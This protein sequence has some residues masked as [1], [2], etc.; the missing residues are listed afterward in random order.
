[1]LRRL[2]SKMR[3]DEQG[4]T[5]IELMIV[6]LVILVLAAILLPQFGLAR[7]RARKAS[8]VSNQRNLETAVAMWQTDNPSTSL[9]QG[10]MSGT[11]V[12]L[13]GTLSGTPQYALSGTYKEPDDTGATQTS[14]AD[15]F[16]S[17]GGATAN[18]VAPSYGHVV[19]R[20]AFGTGANPDP[21][22]GI[23]PI[24]EQGSGGNTLNHARGASASP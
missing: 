4:F 7:E 2:M 6:I 21:W 24:T 19:C 10:E 14:G 11:S 15:Y 9:T 20:F 22:G 8:C 5:L 1:M 16:L 12:P 23:G 13:A 17:A 3:R 18:A